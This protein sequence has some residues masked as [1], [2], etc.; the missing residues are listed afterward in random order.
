ML[1]ERTRR[2]PLPSLRYK[3]GADYTQKL[4]LLLQPCVLGYGCLMLGP[5]H[6]FR[7]L[8]GEYLRMLGPVLLD[9]V[10]QRSG[11]HSDRLRDM[12][13]RS[14]R[15]E[16]ELDGIIL[17]LL[18]ALLP[19]GGHDCE[20]SLEPVSLNHTAADNAADTTSGLWLIMDHTARADIKARSNAEHTRVVAKFAL[21][22]RPRTE[23][24]H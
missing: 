4:V 18:S 5:G 2:D 12:I 8:G 22:R 19:A 15:G 9:P 23:R 10:P 6:R 7:L 1:P 13:D 20:C 24:D 11:L 14:V 21:L 16:E 3:E 17:E